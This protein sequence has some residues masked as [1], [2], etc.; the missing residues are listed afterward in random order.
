MGKLYINLKRLKI[1][2][3]ILILYIPFFKPG[4]FSQIQIID[5]LYMILYIFSLFCTLA[6]VLNRIIRNGYGINSS[7]LF[8]TTYSI[9]LVLSSLIND[10]EVI[11]AINESVRVIGVFL[12]TDMIIRRYTK[13]FL[14]VISRLFVVLSLINIVL[15]LIYPDGMYLNIQ[16]EIVRDNLYGAWYSNN[17][18][19]G[20]QNNHIFYYI[21]AIL[22][23]YIKE[24]LSGNERKNNYI[25]MSLI[26]YGAVIYRFKAGTIISMTIFLGL[27][28]LT[29]ERSMC[30]FLNALSYLVANIVLFVSIVMLRIQRIFSWLIVKILHKDLTLTNRT[31]IWDEALNSIKKNLL[32]GCGYENAKVVV[33]KLG[34]NSTHSHYLWV[35]Y[36]G[37]ILQLA[38]F[39]WYL[40]KISKDMFRARRNRIVQATACAV[41]AILIAW[42]TEA[43][44]SAT[45][46]FILAF[47][48]H[49]PRIEWEVTC[50]ESCSSD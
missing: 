6:M 34:Y 25:C 2:F 12:L 13:T 36:R 19:L 38:I 49:A 30:I 37:G 18:F 29:S 45:I 9:V 7:N 44:T 48:Y 15:M 50:N 14:N 31:G 33:A 10:V 4:Y 24:K 46:F 22:F 35:L 26:C 1:E 21:P 27:L 16:K 5:T 42:Q 28:I 23:T 39:I 8:A 43:I 3:L 40:V 32:L 41:C 20:F 47:A 11:R 17:D